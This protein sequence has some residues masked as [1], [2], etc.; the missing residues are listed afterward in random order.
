MAQTT[1]AA[2]LR[3][4][5]ADEV[6][7]S[8]INFKKLDVRG[9]DDSRLG[10][11]DG[12]I[13]DADSGRVYYTVVDSGGWFT[14]RRLLLPSGHATVDRGARALRVDVSKDTLMQYP[15]FDANRFQAFS[16]DDLRAFERRMGA[17]CCPDEPIEDVAVPSSYFETR[18]HYRQPDWWTAQLS[19]R[20]R[21]RPVATVAS[22]VSPGVREAYDRDLVTA[23]AWEDEPP[24]RQ[25]E[26][27]GRGDDVS[28]HLG[29]RAQPGDVLGLETGGERTYV[30]DTSEDENKRRQSAERTAEE[31]DE[32][33]PRRSER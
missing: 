16:D 9:R 10:E 30:G 23:R 11:V 5:A 26:G 12:F 8:D 29:G 24:R 6:D 28:P 18:R 25:D 19:N 22:G 13:V 20:E 3:Y 2:R 27:I 17:A 33:E 7:N 32:E 14:S 4:L 1:Y 21:F 15:E 31:L